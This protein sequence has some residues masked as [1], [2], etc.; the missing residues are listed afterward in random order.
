MGRCRIQA[1]EHDPM[2]DALMEGFT[3]VATVAALAGYQVEICD[4]RKGLEPAHILE[5]AGSADAVLFPLYLS[6]LGFFKELCSAL[7]ARFPQKPLIAGGPVPSAVPVE[8][9]NFLRA[10]HAVIGEGESSVVPLLDAVL[11]RGGP[12]L[13]AIGGIACRENGVVKINPPGKLPESLDALPFPDYSLWK[14]PGAFITPF[15][16]G[17][18]SVRGCSGQ[19]GFCSKILSRPRVKSAGRFEAELVHL[20]D[21][22]GVKSVTLNDPHLNGGLRGASELCGIFGKHAVSYFCFLR[23]TDVT[24]DLAARLK[25]TGCY[26]AYVGVESYNEDLLRGINKYNGSLAQMDAAVE[27]LSMAGLKV[28]C[29]MIFGLPGETEATLKNNL[30]FIERHNVLPDMHYLTLDPGSPLYSRFS[31]KKGSMDPMEY[32]LSMETD[33]T[34]FI[35]NTCGLVGVDAEAVMEYLGKAWTIKEERLLKYHRSLS[36]G[37][38]APLK[39]SGGAPL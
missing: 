34:G 16:I 17:V 12:G 21:R 13:A 35:R 22:Y 9:L 7:K 30:R 15:S 2:P 27:T 38:A 3:S 28:V 10:D 4:A 20:K 36:P 37:P 1:A 19:C 31:A 33:Q 11:G 24:R 25:E 5:K 18:S 23:V 39:S 32:L 8:A 14:D 6:Q 29:G 26:G